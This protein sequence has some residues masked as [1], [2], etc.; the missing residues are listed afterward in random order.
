MAIMFTSQF[1]YHGFG[2][3]GYQYK[4]TEYRGGEVIFTSEHKRDE[5]VCFHGGSR[6]VIHRVK[7]IS[8]RKRVSVATF[9][10]SAR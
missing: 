8:R 10:Q 9:R 7:A 5:L 1:F 6:E 2:I 4:R 3:Q